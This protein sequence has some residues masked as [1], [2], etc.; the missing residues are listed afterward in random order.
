MPATCRAARSDIRGYMGR[1]LTILVSGNI[2]GTPYQGGATWAVLQYLLGFRQLGHEVYF[3]EPLEEAALQPEGTAL[4]CSINAT[5]FRQVMVDF[6]F[7][8][9][10]ALL[11]TGA[12]QTV[13]LPYARLR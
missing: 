13:G 1:D 4:A 5:Y 12:K 10:S 7:E 6:G 2:A 3:I 11:L 8:Q 9:F